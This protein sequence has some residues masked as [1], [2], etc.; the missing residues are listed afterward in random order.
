M[1]HFQGMN[2]SYESVTY[3]YILYK[4]CTLNNKQNKLHKNNIEGAHLYDF[5]FRDRRSL[6]GSFA[7]PPTTC[8]WHGTHKYRH[9]PEKKGQKKLRKHHKFDSSHIK[10]LVNFEF[11]VGSVVVLLN[12]ISKAF[13]KKR[14]EKIGL[15]H[16]CRA[17]SFV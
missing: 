14:N 8:Y 11:F 15:C 7:Y 13:K 16:E 2:F 9:L 6:S 12:L 1:H 10:I 17:C 3:N 5:W 4:E